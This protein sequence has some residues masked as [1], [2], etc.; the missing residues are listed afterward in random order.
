MLAATLPPA[1]QEARIA[2]RRDAANQRLL[3]HKSALLRDAPELNAFRLLANSSPFFSDGSL[4]RV[5]PVATGFVWHLSSGGPELL[6]ALTP[7]AS[8]AAAAIA[9]ERALVLAGRASNYTVVDIG[10]GQ[11]RLNLMD[12]TGP[13]AQALGES[14]QVF[15]SV[16]AANAALIPLAARFATLRLES[17]VSP[18]ERK[19][20]HYSGI[21]DTRRRRALALTA[22]F[23]EIIDDPPGGGQFGKRWAL[24]ELPGNTGAVLLVSPIRYEAGTDAQAIALA[25][26]AIVQVLRYG[27]DEWNYRIV[28]APGNTFQIELRDPANTLFAI[29]GTGL[30]TIAAARAALEAAIAHLYQNFGA[31]RML[32]VE[33][34]LLRPRHAGDPFLS[35]PEGETARERDPYSQR[36]SLVLPS[37]SA[38]DFSLP[39]GTAPLTNIAPDRFRDV[40]FRRHFEGMVRR[41]CPSHLLPTVYWV[42]REAPGTPPANASYDNFERT[43]FAW[44]ETVLIPGETPAT[45]DDARNELVGALNAIANDAA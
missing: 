12:G 36:M 33:H 19:V 6:R 18:F 25:E 1:Q 24:H 43:Y 45:M 9:A 10:G 5:E 37:G 7:A 40:E 16:A 42:D 28:P 14:V 13:G 22:M 3:R 32:L 31:E 17:S 20:A 41:A 15:A 21:R 30:A 11:R 27:L 34:L 2:E 29:H 35:L 44:L 8:S 4:L 26:E 39:S 38:R 23:F